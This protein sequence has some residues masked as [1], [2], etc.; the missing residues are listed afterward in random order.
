M[1]WAPSQGTSSPSFPQIFAA[2][3]DSKE[4]V[5]GELSDFG[6]EAH[7]AVGEQDLGLAEAAGVEEDLAGAG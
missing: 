4:V 5:T 6:C 3:L 1:S 7:G 2:M